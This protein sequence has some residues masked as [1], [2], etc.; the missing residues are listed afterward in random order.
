LDGLDNA[1]AVLAV[2]RGEQTVTMADLDLRIG[3]IV[4]EKPVEQD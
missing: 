3:R 4:A 2:R 1:A